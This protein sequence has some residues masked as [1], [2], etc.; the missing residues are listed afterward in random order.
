MIFSWAHRGRDRR[1]KTQVF[2]SLKC[3]KGYRVSGRRPKSHLSE[4]YTP[5]N[6]EATMEKIKLNLGHPKK[7]LQ[8]E[9]CCLGGRNCQEVKY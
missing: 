2:A 8:I 6:R 7:T 3:K 1:S 4:N 5:T 9:E